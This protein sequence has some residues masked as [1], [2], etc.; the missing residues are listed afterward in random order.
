MPQNEEGEFELVLGNR[1]LLSVFFIIV[2]LM[3]VCLTMGYVLGRKAGPAAGKAKSAT[4]VVDPTQPENSTAASAALPPGDARVQTPP[5]AAIPALPEPV[6]A[7]P[8]QAQPPAAETKPPVAEAKP[9]VS[10]ASAASPAPDAPAGVEEPGSG[11][12]FLQV[13]AARPQDAGV[14]AEELR[15]KGFPT[16]LAPGPQGLVR[17]LVG[18]VQ[19]SAERVKT[20]VRLKDEAGMDSFVKTYR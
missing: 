3:G 10:A 1:Q 11:Q 15:K 8:A 5:A 12:T 17:V 19:D 9:P 2:I 6:A 7:A 14:L 4:I 16:R 18:P 20:R 13:A